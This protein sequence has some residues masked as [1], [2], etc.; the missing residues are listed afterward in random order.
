MAEKQNGRQHVP[1]FMCRSGGHDTGRRK[2]V[3]PE[4]EDTPWR[5]GRNEGR[6]STGSP[7]PI[8]LRWRALAGSAS[9][10]RP[11]KDRVTHGRRRS[12]EGDGKSEAGY[13]LPCRS[14]FS[15]TRDTDGRVAFNLCRLIPA[16]CA[17]RAQLDLAAPRVAAIRIPAGIEPNAR[18][19]ATGWRGRRA[20]P[21]RQAPLFAYVRRAVRRRLHASSQ[22]RQEAAQI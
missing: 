18:R 11:T 22:R 15:T 10:T 5:G 1:S 9:S 16:K 2:G 4:G 17:K 3:A 12:N 14:Q 7:E 6:Q 19:C 21:E 13:R 8:G 20:P